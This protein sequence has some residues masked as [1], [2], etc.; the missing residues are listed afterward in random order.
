MS[1]VS[2]DK[3]T[4]L[5]DLKKKETGYVDG[6]SGL[7]DGH[8]DRLRGMGLDL[9]SEIICEHTIPFGKSKVFNVGGFQISLPKDLAQ[10]VLIQR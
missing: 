6:F 4:S 1:E 8:V 7:A 5:W 3:K 9:Q 10:K 2:V